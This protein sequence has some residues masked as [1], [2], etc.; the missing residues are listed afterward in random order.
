[1]AD[2]LELAARY[3]DEGPEGLR[4]VNQPSGELSE[5][6][7]GI[8]IVE[9]FSHVVCLDTGDGLVLFDT[10]L[11]GFGERVRSAVRGW[12]DARIHAIAYTHGHIDHVGGA[13]RWLDEAVERRQPRP[14]VLGHVNV[15]PRFERYRL[16]DG[17]NQEISRRQWG[18]R[19]APRGAYGP[20]R[21]VEP[22]RT[23]QDRLS[24]RV[25]ELQLELQHTL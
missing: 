2:L 12:S 24:L 22:D 8:A 18:R 23:V 5:L 10:S 21:W 7:P 13:A 15:A 17:Y 14:L 25:G 19:L 9:A 3:I 11:E 6:A 20:S 1:M 4:P 16:T